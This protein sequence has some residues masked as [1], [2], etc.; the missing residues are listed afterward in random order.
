MVLQTIAGSLETV[1]IV[2]HTGKSKLSNSL[3]DGSESIGDLILEADCGL[4]HL[5]DES[6]RANA[7]EMAPSKA[8]EINNM[9]F[10][11][12]KE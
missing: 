6:I 2:H 1:I 9:K 5:S 11:E 3:R 4:T 7:R 12:I 8:E 10:G